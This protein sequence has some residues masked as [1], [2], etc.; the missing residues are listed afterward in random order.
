MAK[1]GET[2]VYHLNVNSG[3]LPQNATPADADIVTWWQ[4]APHLQ[5]EDVLLCLRTMQQ[6]GFLRS[7]SAVQ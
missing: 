4:L 1:L 6:Q 2:R 3:T 5:N 7:S